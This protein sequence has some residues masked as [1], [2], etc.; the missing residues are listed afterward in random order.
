MA[1]KIALTIPLVSS[2]KFNT[3]TQFNLLFSRSYNCFF[4]VFSIRFQQK[5]RYR[6]FKIQKKWIRFYFH[7]P[8]FL[9]SVR[10]FWLCLFTLYRIDSTKVILYTWLLVVFFQNWKWLI[11]QLGHVYAENKKKG[12]WVCLSYRFDEYPQ[13]NK[14]NTMN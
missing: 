9:S 1:F 8:F 7:F 13:N 12:L 3:S 4:F 6:F 11:I 5:T 2:R 10:W 14:D